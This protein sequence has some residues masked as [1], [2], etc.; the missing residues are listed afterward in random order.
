MV[1][2]EAVEQMLGYMYQI[3]HALLMMLRSEEDDIQIC[4][5]KFDDISFSKDNLLDSMIQTKHHIGNSGNLTNAS[6][7]LWRTIKSW[8]DSIADN[9]IDVNRTKFIIVTTAT[10]PINSASFMLKENKPSENIRNSEKALKILLETANKSE[11][12]K[13]KPY[14]KAFISLN[15]ED[16]NQLVNNIYVFD[17]CEDIND[18]K[19]IIKQYLKYTTLPAYEERMYEQL[20]GWWFNTVLDCLCSEEVRLIHKT[21]LRMKMADIRDEY[22]KD[23]LP[24]D[25]HFQMSVTQ[26]DLDEKDRIFIEQLKLICISQKRIDTAIRDYFRAYK[27]RASWIR[28]DLLYI[29]ELDDY[30]R[31]L[32]DEWQRLFDIMCEDLDEYGDELE[33]KTKHNAGR[34]LFNIISDR[35]I[36]I[37]DKCDEPFVMR[38]SYHMMA[39][40]LEIGWHIDF[41]KRL[42]HLLNR[43]VNAS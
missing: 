39:N 12:E 23:N 3:R 5:E 25:V 20:E 1:N 35:N 43:Q 18:T 30:E 27:Q 29:N 2:H 32:A 17:K 8:C 19:V 16:R 11:N 42:C 26:D 28:N 24:I 21:Q 9:N 4:I 34:K 40:K 33:E 13:H 36:R 22:S 31:K 7:D 14:Y 10:A 15:S 38:G 6:T 41:E 37:R